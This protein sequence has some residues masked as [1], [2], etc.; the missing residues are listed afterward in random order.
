VEVLPAESIVTAPAA[1][2]HL[3]L[4]TMRDADQDFVDAPFT[5][6]LEP[7][8]LAAAHAA[9]RAPEP[10]AAGSEGKPAPAW[11]AAV[12]AGEARELHGLCLWFDID[13]D[14][15]RFDP[16]AVAGAASD[17]SASTGAS[18][19]ATLAGAAAAAEGGKPGAAWGV[20]DDGMPALEEEGAPASA[21]AASAGAAGAATAARAA[22][23]A[24]EKAAVSFSTGPHVKPTHWAQTFFLF[25]RP[26]AVPASGAM[27]GTLTMTRDAVNPREYRFAIALR[28][29]PQGTPGAEATGAAKPGPV[30]LQQTFHMR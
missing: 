12:A 20:E 4:L 14:A 15:E 30:L 23:P 7:A 16:A 28:E 27:A 1:V 9:A 8:R 18:T 17:T 25:E 26:L 24:P 29:A 6:Q 5:L 10:G 2:R 11:T 19:S 13:F 22:A 3:N 21:A